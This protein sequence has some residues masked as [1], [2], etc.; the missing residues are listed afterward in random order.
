MMLLP[1]SAGMVLVRRRADLD[2]AFTQR[3]PYLFHSAGDGLDLDQGRRSF[4]CSRRADAL[5]VWIAVQRYGSRGI[6]ALYDRLCA[7]TAALHDLVA[8]HS[9]FAALHEPETNILCFR[10]VGSHAVDDPALD[11]INRALRERYNASGEGWVTTTVVGGRRVLRVTVMN[12]QTTPAH[13]ERLLDG[14]DRMA[15]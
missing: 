3:A 13:L 15:G 7:L 1:L 10:W 4:L 2:A 14:L 8:G 9:R 11:E 12:P 5:K 6:A